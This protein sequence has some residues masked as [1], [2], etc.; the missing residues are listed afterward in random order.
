MKKQV[1]KKNK[2]IGTEKTEPI[3]EKIVEK[4]EGNDSDNVVKQPD[5]KHKPA[6]KRKTAK[7][8]VE[9]TAKE[10]TIETKEKPKKTDVK[11]IQL[12]HDLK[13]KQQQ[14]VLKEKQQ[15]KKKPTKKSKSHPIDGKK[16]LDAINKRKQ[17]EK[18]FSIA[19]AALTRE[20][21]LSPELEVFAAVS[22]GSDSVVMLDILKYLSLQYG[23]K[24]SIIHYNHSL[25][26]KAS[27]EDEKFVA[28]LATKY[29]LSFFS[30]KGFV[31]LY[32]EAHS[33]GI[34]E[35]ARVMRYRFF[36]KICRSKNAS[37]LATA[38]NADDNAE[39]FLLNL[40]RGSGLTG[41]SGIP[42]SRAFAKKTVI[43]RPLLKAKKQ[44]IVDYAKLNNLEWREDR[45]NT[46]LIYKRN[47]VRHELIPLLKESYSPA[48]VEIL[49]RT[50][51]F[52]NGADAFVKEYIEQIYPLLIAGNQNNILDL[53]ISYLEAYD[54][55]IQGEMLQH[56]I[57]RNFE[58]GPIPLHT[59]DRII[60]LIKS[61][62]NSKCEVNKEVEAMRGRRTLIFYKL[63]NDIRLEEKIEKIGAYEF[64]RIKIELSKVRKNQVK[65]S[66]DPNIEFF[67]A[68][69]LPEVLTIRSKQDGDM[70]SPLGMVGSMKVSDFLT[71]EKIPLLERKNIVVLSAKQEIIWV[72][73]LRASDKFK[74]TD[75]TKQF[76]KATFSI[77]NEGSDSNL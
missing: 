21:V 19:D 1:D 70:F 33:C 27:D 74:I 57:S 54:E 38:H 2:E 7:N 11:E 49:N 43:I 50:I 77:K 8:P 28:R 5:K 16:L 12:E 35:A 64:G 62:V 45:S 6:A 55:F 32:A 75:S 23:F 71:N 37:I 53:K 18:L 15:Q 63:T 66:M 44:E 67:D 42:E 34:E 48:I 36:E 61:P 59:V 29:G 10:K 46:S 4:N 14:N 17:N 25:R 60:K 76:I 26:G 47:K 9:K 31:K 24:L 73:G 13:E 56:A 58:I 72:C 65:F 69:L 39:T 20:F 68:D 40:M 41:L 22:G 52:I 3:V 51:R 30:Q